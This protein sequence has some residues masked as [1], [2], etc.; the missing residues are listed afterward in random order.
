MKVIPHKRGREV[1]AWLKREVAEQKTRYRKI[2][3]DQDKL[4]PQR[5]KWVAEFLQRIQTRGVHVHFDMMRK[6]R[7]EEIP[8]RPK[9][10]FRVVF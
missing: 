1:E 2:V 4:A 5:D 6:V 9:R 7:P 3:A 8:V 10:K